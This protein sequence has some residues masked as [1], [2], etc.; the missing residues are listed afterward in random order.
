[1]AQTDNRQGNALP[2]RERVAGKLVSVGYP[3]HRRKISRNTRG[4]LFR[5]PARQFSA[6]SPCQSCRDCSIE[7]RNILTLGSSMLAE[8]P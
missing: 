4:Q 5:L 6:R 7:H 8:F 1:M 2:A 3:L